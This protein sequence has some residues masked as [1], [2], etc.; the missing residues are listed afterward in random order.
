[1][2]QIYRRPPMAKCDFNKTAKHF[3]W[4]HTSAWIFSCKFA[5]YFRDTFLQEHLWRV[6]SVYIL[7]CFYLG[8]IL[9]IVI[10]LLMSSLSSANN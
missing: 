2:E 5:A 6:A 3:Y 4:N 7:E 1:M 8:V 10:V 9:R